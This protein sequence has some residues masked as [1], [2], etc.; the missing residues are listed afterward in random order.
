M[1]IALFKTVARNLARMHSDE[2]RNFPAAKAL[3]VRTQ[4]LA[5]SFHQLNVISNS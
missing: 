1:I 4:T 3:A 5:G 2:V